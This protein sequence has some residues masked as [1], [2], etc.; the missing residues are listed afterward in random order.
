MS[1]QPKNLW[2]KFVEQPRRFFLW[3]ALV[4]LLLLCL[5]FAVEISSPFTPSPGLRSAAAF[6]LVGLV[7][8]F[9]V[10]FFGFF[11]GLIP[12][13]KPLMQWIVRR[14]VFLAAC[15]VTLVALFYAV[16]N[17]RGKRAWENFKREAAARGELF[18]VKDIIPPPAPDGENIVATPLFRELAN[19]FDPEWRRLHT[20]PNGMTNWEDRLHFRI[21]RKGDNGPDVPAA[22][23]MFSQRTQLKAWQDYY[24]N[25]KD[26]P[27]E[28][29]NEFPIASQSQTPAA[30]VLLALSEN[31]ALVEELR[32]ATTKTRA[33]FPLR[34]EDGF[35]ALLPHLARLKSINQFLALRA[36]AELEAGQTNQAAMDVEL[37]LRIVDLVREE[38]LLISQLVRLAQL[39][40][41]LN[42]LWEGLAEHRWS[43]AHLI[44]F[45][46]RL[47]QVDFLADYHH[48][49]RG[50]RAFCTWT[51]DYL[52]RQRN[53]DIIEPRADQ[54]DNRPEG[55]EQVLGTVLG[56]LVPRG[57]FD[58]NK[59]SIGR[60]HIELTMPAVNTES[61]QISPSDTKN[62]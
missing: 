28:R 33:R 34:Y 45:E 23:W 18:E 55:L 5:C 30:D 41:A 43:D 22:F 25:P 3:L 39:Q 44:G 52:R 7:V 19:E 8:A 32:T 50:E 35:G 57:W 20:G 47:S 26:K 31:D 6:A 61:R 54:S 21:S 49:M 36:A 29:D 2:A 60:M 24:R 11:L 12:P 14:S 59:A 13:L 38:P 53:P 58:Q 46:R 9:I 62:V 42:P 1:E 51:I 10:G 16:E 40:I 4:S 37:S 56:H 15:L 48:A 17:W 27:G